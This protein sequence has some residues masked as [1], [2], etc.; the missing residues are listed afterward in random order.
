[1]RR[2]LHHQRLLKDRV[3][4]LAAFDDLFVGVGF[5]IVLFFLVKRISLAM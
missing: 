2:E 3:F 1:M 5:Q 4:G